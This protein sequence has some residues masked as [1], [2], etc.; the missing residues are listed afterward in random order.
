MFL[1]ASSLQTDEALRTSPWRPITHVA[2]KPH[3]STKARVS[4]F[5]RLTSGQAPS[6]SCASSD[7]LLSPDAHTLRLGPRGCPLHFV[8]HLVN[9]KCWLLVDVDMP[10][11]KLAV[12]GIV[13]FEYRCCS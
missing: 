1:Q 12:S 8:D 7:A 13:T 5:E 3:R 10:T 4:R 9:S 6:P 2:G 11:A